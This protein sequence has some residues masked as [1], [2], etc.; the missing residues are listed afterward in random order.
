MLLEAIDATEYNSYNEEGARL[1][2]WSWIGIF[3]D[4]PGQPR[5]SP[6]SFGRAAPR[7]EGSTFD[8]MGQTVTNI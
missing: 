4:F 2:V 1:Q 5:W 8:E 3:A 6:R 7:S